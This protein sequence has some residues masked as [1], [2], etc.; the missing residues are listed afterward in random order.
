MSAKATKSKNLKQTSTQ[1]QT[2]PRKI[3]PLKTANESQLNEAPDLRTI[4]TLEEIMKARGWD[5]QLT[6]QFLSAV[7]QIK[8]KLTSR[9]IGA[10]S[11]PDDLVA[12]STSPVSR[13]AR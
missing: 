7:V 4:I 1:V 8:P 5:K 9:S 6:P 11:D 13:H 3:S 12:R 2:S 10:E